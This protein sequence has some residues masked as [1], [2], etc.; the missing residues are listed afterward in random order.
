MN[1]SIIIPVYNEKGTLKEIFRLVQLTPYAKEIIAVDDASVDGSRE[2]LDR[3]AAEYENVK[4]FHH[5]QNQGKGAALRT[6]FEQ[7]SGDVV[8]I[9]DAR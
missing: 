6:G 8:I 5:R 2:I 7:V 1:L 3:L 9:Q 4:V